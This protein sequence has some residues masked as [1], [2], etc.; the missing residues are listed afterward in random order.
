MEKGRTACVTLLDRILVYEEE[1]Q[2]GIGWIMK[3]E[4]ESRWETGLLGRP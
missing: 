4:R 3:R 2:I 1:D